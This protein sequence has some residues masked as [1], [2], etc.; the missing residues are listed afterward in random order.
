MFLLAQNTS[1][2]GK[3]FGWFVNE[4]FE[5][6]YRITPAYSLFITIILFTLIIKL[7]LFP[8]MVKQQKSMKQTQKI[9]PQIKAIQD[10]YKNRNDQE[11]QQKM[12]QELQAIYSQN[13]ASPFTGCLL[14]FIQIPIIYALFGVCKQIYLHISK[15]GS[16]Y[17]KLASIFMGA[18]DYKPLLDNLA[19]C[20]KLTGKQALDFTIVDDVKSLFITL[21]NADWTALIADLNDKIDVNLVNEILIKKN[22]IETAFGINLI[23]RPSIHSYSIILPLITVAVTFLS[24]RK[25]L[26]QNNED[27][28]EQTKGMMKGMT[29]FMYF[30]IVS[31][32]FTSLSLP[33]ALS[34]YWTLNSLF[35]MVQ[36]KILKNMFKDKDDDG[37]DKGKKKDYV[38]VKKVKEIKE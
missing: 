30:M 11:S 12:A 29:G 38:D 25:S 8:L 23:N 31:I 14:S 15:L 37:D 22:E 13:N 7:L 1:A 6:V 21:S 4:L 5:L 35:T 18:S 34:I 33:A 24:I 27:M 19:V 28:D 16:I 36:S 9:Q 26:K 32:F 10:K 20:K 17:D 3:L 2:L